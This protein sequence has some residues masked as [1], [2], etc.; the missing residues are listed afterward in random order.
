VLDSVQSYVANG[1][2]NALPIPVQGI[3]PLTAWVT[4]PALEQADGPRAHVWGGSV[5]IS[6]QTA[7]RGPGFKKF[8]W[9][10]DVYLVYLTTPDDGL[11]CE[12]F[13]KIIDAVMWAFFTTTMPLFIDVNGI[14]MGPNAVNATDTQIQKIG[15][16]P[17][18]QYP[19][20]KMVGPMQMLWYTALIQLDVLE[21]VQA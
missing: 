19:T 20:E 12:P 21:V 1:I 2:L 4:P 6:R 18:L 10:I 17:R 15:E 13:P 16:S 7:P 3:P 14:P 9:T 11:D 5:G 8:P